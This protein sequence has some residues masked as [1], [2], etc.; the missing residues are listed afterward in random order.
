MWQ[1]GVLALNVSLENPSWILCTGGNRQVPR[2][3]GNSR[4]PSAWCPDPSHSADCCLNDSVFGI[5]SGGLSSGG[6]FKGY[7]ASS[8]KIGWVFS[9]RLPLAELLFLLEFQHI[10]DFLAPRWKKRIWD[11]PRRDQSYTYSV[12]SQFQS[13]RLKPARCRE[14]IHHD[15]GPHQCNSSTGSNTLTTHEFCVHMH[16]LCILCMSGNVVQW[17]VMQH[18]IAARGRDWGFNKHRDLLQM[19]P[20]CVFFQHM[21]CDRHWAI[22]S[23]LR[24]C[25]SCRAC[26]N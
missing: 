20:S 19:C 23:P 7:V 26:I 17:N 13:T 22:S 5:Q 25:K 2:W 8:I 14:W 24:G 6:F 1:S 16:I 21:I 10:N 12:Y 18:S 9:K 4:R 11:L 15:A 3:R